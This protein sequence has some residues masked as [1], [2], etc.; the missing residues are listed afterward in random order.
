MQC[1][2]KVFG[3]SNYGIM[4]IFYNAFRK[5]IFFKIW[6]FSC[7]DCEDCPFFGCDV[8]NFVR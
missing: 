6:P 1:L 8:M 4:E 5:M 7:S 3:L 2:L